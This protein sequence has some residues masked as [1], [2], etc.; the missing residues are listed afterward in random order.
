MANSLLSF[1]LV[2]LPDFALLPFSGFIEKLRFTADE[3]DL[4]RQKFCQ[5]QVASINQL[6]LHSS[7][8]IRVESD[9]ALEAVDFQSV[10][11]LILFGC[12]SSQQACLQADL[13]RPWLRKALAQGIHLVSVD[14]ACFTLAEAGVLKRKKVAVHWRHRQ[15]FK[16]LFP[17]IS[18]LEND[19]FCTDGQISSC[20][21]GTAAI[22]LAV[23]LLSRHLGREMALKGLADMMVDESRGQSH[24]LRSIEVSLPPNELLHRA[25]ALM[26]SWMAESKTTADIASATGISRRQMDRQFR[27]SFG[28]T[29]HAYW[30][31]MKLQYVC[32][33]LTNSHYSL[34]QIALETGIKDVSYLNRLFK[35]HTGITPGEYRRQNL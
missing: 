27:E 7:S 18:V 29:A 5:W 2:P 17:D 28:V 11:Y 31:E 21:G 10:D 8:G 24:L 9:I 20:G 32:W 4:S 33:R 14:N 6:P 13:V 35:K 30:I 34:T 22:D 12:R 25:I 3:E 15:E 23:E 19:L 26:R 1:L 16:S